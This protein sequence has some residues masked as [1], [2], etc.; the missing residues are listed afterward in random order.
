MCGYF[1]ARLTYVCQT[2]L[3][4]VSSFATVNIPAEGCVATDPNMRQLGGAVVVRL[5]R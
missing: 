5:E 2:K 3:E 1:P 4:L